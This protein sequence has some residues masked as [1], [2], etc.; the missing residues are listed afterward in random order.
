MTI[1]AFVVPVLLCVVTGCI[2]AIL[3][4]IAAIKFA[5]PVD[6]TQVKIRECLPGA[7]CGACGFVGCDDYAAALA[8]DHSI[9][10]NK[11]VP[12][13]ASAAAG[14]AA[15]LGVDAGSAEA[16]VANVMC[17]GLNDC[18]K[19]EMDYQGYKSCS[20]V[21][22][23]FGGP[24]TCKFGCIGL[25]DCTKACAFDAIEVCNGVAKVNRDKCVG[26]GACANTCPQKIIDILPKTSRVTV[27]C[28]SHDAAKATKDACTAGCVGCKM[29][30]KTCKFDAIHVEGNVAKI[31]ASK[32]KNCGMCAKACPRHIIHVVPKPGTAKPVVK[33]EAPKTEAPAEAAPAAEAPKTEA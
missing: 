6:E 3:L 8:A 1:S 2:C 5:V 12:G 26:C 20:A 27:G 21:K 23:F 9:A 17:S 4:T 11:C 14:I 24:G 25:G 7:N 16:K 18:T 28:S 15:V 30:E 10:P 29:C 32:C 22:Q 33:V 31:D 13:G 19:P